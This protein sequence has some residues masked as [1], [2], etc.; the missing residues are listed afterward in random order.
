MSETAGSAATD[1]ENDDR[2]E[3]GDTMAVLRKVAEVLGGEGWGEEGRVNVKTAAEKWKDHPVEV[4]G[5]RSAPP[6]WK[7]YWSV[8]KQKP[9]YQHRASRR[10]VW[11]LPQSAWST[12]EQGT[13]SPTER[14]CDVQA[15]ETDAGD[16]LL[17]FHS[18]ATSDQRAADSPHVLSP[19]ATPATHDSQAQRRTQPDGPAHDAGESSVEPADAQSGH[20]SSDLHPL[21]EECLFAGDKALPCRHDHAS[22]CETKILAEAQSTLDAD[23]D[24]HAPHDRRHEGSLP[25]IGAEMDM[26]RAVAMLRDQWHTVKSKPPRFPALQKSQKEDHGATNICEED[27]TV[28]DWGGENDASHQ[29]HVHQGEEVRQADLS[30]PTPKK[31]IEGSPSASYQNEVFAVDMHVVF[32]QLLAVIAKQQS[33]IQELQRRELETLCLQHKE[34]QE[35]R[36]KQNLELLVLMQVWAGCEYTHGHAN[37]L[38]HARLVIC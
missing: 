22:T 36:E 3:E 10:V 25:M 8:T 35:A 16:P 31:T 21:M 12:E 18:P 34:G 26:E 4:R 11:E 20:D 9:Y 1:R 13:T 32:K 17:Q 24:L 33:Q 27:E 28:N 7:Q 15:G 29:P 38:H 30:P 37:A 5:G 14:H 6:G 23:V 2:T 19:H